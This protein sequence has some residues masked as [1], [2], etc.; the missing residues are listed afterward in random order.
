MKQ[1][2]KLEG[3]RELE[4]ALGEDLPRATAKGVLTRTGKKAMKPLEARMAELAPVDEGKY[5]DSFATKKVKASRGSNGRYARSSGVEIASGPTGKQGGGVGSW[6]E[7]G[8]VN[9]PANP[10]IRPAVD[11]KGLEVI[12]SVRDTLATEIR[13]SAERIARKNAR[14]G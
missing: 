6:Q 2:F 10:H 8:T 12:Q 7:R 9:M 3:F 11:E 13:K 5:R 1:T 4:R 14:K